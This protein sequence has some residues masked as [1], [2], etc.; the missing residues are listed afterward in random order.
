MD[1]GVSKDC[2]A[3][4]AVLIRLQNLALSRQEQRRALSKQ[5]RSS[6]PQA[7]LRLVPCKLGELFGSA[8]LCNLVRPSSTPAAWISRATPPPAARARTQPPGRAAATHLRHVGGGET[9]IPETSH[10][11]AVERDSRGSR[12][13]QQEHLLGSAH[14]AAL[15]REHVARGRARAWGRDLRARAWTAR[16]VAG[17]GREGTGGRGCG[18]LGGEALASLGGGAAGPWAGFSVMVGGAGVVGRKPLRARGR[19]GLRVRVPEA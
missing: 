5:H 13:R 15:P 4:R 11:Q 16:Q 6:S 17:A 8:H 9:P 1:G 10:S 18:Q 2:E 7:G 3:E 14:G 12:K 19:A